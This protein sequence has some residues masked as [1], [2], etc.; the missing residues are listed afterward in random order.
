MK[1]SLLCI[2]V[3]FGLHPVARADETLLS[4]LTC[5]RHLG[6]AAGLVPAPQSFE[7]LG[8]PYFVTGSPMLTL[9]CHR[10]MSE[11]STTFW[12][13]EFRTA[14]FYSHI[15]FRQRQLP[16]WGTVAVGVG[17]ELS[18]IHRV[19][20]YFETGYSITG[21]GLA[22]DY[23]PVRSD[24]SGL[25]HGFRLQSTVIMNFTLGFQA[26]LLYTVTADRTPEIPTAGGEE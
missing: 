17:R 5:E 14:P 18:D 1:R 25:R 11:E 3:F 2:A 26:A 12:N 21:P 20:A 19:M 10:A 7:F 16:Q 4:G 8:T 24:K 23:R 22:I 6:L 13:A 9:G 15:G